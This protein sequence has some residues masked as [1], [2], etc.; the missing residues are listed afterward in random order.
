MSHLYA[1]SLDFLQLLLNVS[2]FLLLPLDVGLDHSCPLL[3]LLFKMLH[4]IYL[5]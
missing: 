1:L 3:Q 5:C 4:G 2:Q